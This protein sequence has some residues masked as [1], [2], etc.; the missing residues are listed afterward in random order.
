[1]FRALVVSAIV[2]L[3]I[4]WVLYFFVLGR[5]KYKAS[6]LAVITIF[7]T[8]YY[9]HLYLS[10]KDGTISLFGPKNNLQGHTFFILLLI[11][12]LIVFTKLIKHKLKFSRV[13][14]NYLV[15]FATA[16]LLINLYPIVRQWL[17]TRDLKNIKFGS[18]VQT[19]SGRDN[20]ASPDIYYLIFDRYANQKVLKDVYKFDNSPFLNTLKKKGFY[21]ADNSAANYPAT[22]F[23]L[24]SSLNIDYLPSELN[25]RSENGLF[26]SILHNAIENN[27]VVTFLK[28]QGYSFVNIGPWWN[29]T[30]YSKYAD[31]NLFNPTGV[32]VF[33]KKVD[34]QEHELLLFQDTIFW[35]FSKKPIKL[36][37]RTLYGR[38]Y[39]SGDTAG[40]AIHKQTFLHQFEMLKRISKVQISPKFIFAH[41]LSPHDP[42]VVDAKCQHMP[43]SLEHEYLLYVK[44][45]QCANTY[46]LETISYILENS[47]KDPII[48]AQSDEG[49]Y[50][51][52]FRRN[53]ELDW[54]KAST[55]LLHQKEKIL[56]SYYF[57]DQNYTQLYSN[58]SPV[59]SFRIIFNQY[60]GTKLPL[61]KDRHFFSESR[62][63][64]FRLFEVTDRFAN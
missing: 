4:Y 47:P 44:Q 1:M 21:V 26:T 27:Q 32:V 60:F 43:K 34:M 49:P 29:T 30:K 12:V 48:I 58:T 24:A 53:K 63:K 19:A 6:V 45:L 23:S 20:S 28:K 64:R 8:L 25:N 39:P 55:Q 52:E 10:Y 56:S 31:L 57:P 40:R 17:G 54:S 9:R 14:R 13:F 22:S 62:S 3:L 7:F 50:P 5:N 36:R 16:L 11:L 46:I 59:N 15:L 38:T 2:G 37:G 35:Q 42:Y 18:V 51:V 61:L 41:V 33:N